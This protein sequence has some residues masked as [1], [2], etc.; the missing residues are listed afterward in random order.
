MVDRKDY[1]SGKFGLKASKFAH[2]SFANGIMLQKVFVLWCGLYIAPIG[3]IFCI[4][5]SYTRM[6]MCTKFG[7][8]WINIFGT[9][10]VKHQIGQNGVGEASIP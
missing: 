1:S 5:Q 3:M 10:S 6:I 4:A 7:L 2:T 9:S 8:I